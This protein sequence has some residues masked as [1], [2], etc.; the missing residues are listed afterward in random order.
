[1]VPDS[2]VDAAVGRMSE[3]PNAARMNV[4]DAAKA[5]VQ[6]LNGHL[7]DTG[8]L[9][10]ATVQ[11]NEQTVG[12][13]ASSS[14][15]NIETILSHPEGQPLAAHDLTAARDTRDAILQ[16]ANTLVERFQA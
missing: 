9:A 13:S 5:L 2:V 10:R 8:Q 16:H 3:S 15:R 4:S 12:M 14:Y 1:K 6:R 7:E 11:T